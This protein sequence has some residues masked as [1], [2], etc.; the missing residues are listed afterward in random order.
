MINQRKRASRRNY[1]QSFSWTGIC[2]LRG[3][4]FTNTFSKCFLRM[5][6]YVCGR[7]N[8]NEILGYRNTISP[9]RL[10]NSAD[11]IYCI[12]YI[13][14]QH[15][16]A[17]ARINP[18]DRIR[19]SFSLEFHSTNSVPPKIF[20]TDEIFPW[21]RPLERTVQGF[22]K[23]PV[24]ENPI[25]KT[26]LPKKFLA[27][28]PFP[29][30]YFKKLFPKKFFH[31]SNLKKVELPSQ[32]LDAIELNEERNPCIQSFRKSSAPVLVPKIV[33]GNLFRRLHSLAI[34]PRDCGKDTSL[35]PRPPSDNLRPRKS[36]KVVLNRK[37]IVKK[38]ERTVRP[39][40]ME[41][42]GVQGC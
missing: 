7:E 30:S 1:W 8:K 36:A 42:N 40:R 22:S 39:R 5:R 14:M 17:F 20:F 41:T 33:P 38:T 2:F 4:F 32:K 11:S 12:I 13:H 29:L 25:R 27:Q 37:T 24:L 35:P 3:K 9:V 10:G 21:H 28:I 18:A 15:I 31:S 34:S 23:N 6:I 26:D 19:K 16:Q